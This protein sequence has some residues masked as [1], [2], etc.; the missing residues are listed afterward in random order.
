MYFPRVLRATSNSDI[1]NRRSRETAG[2]EPYQLT[3]RSRR[4]DG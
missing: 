2:S 3:K 1:A 4:L